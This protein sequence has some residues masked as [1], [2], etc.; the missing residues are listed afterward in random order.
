[1]TT[2]DTTIVRNNEATALQN[3]IDSNYKIKEI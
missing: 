1:V 3:Q 2:A